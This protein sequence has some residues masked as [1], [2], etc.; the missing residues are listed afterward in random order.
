MKINFK[1]LYSESALWKIYE[2]FA[3]NG[4]L[5]YLGA[6]FDNDTK[7]QFDKFIFHEKH[8]DGRDTKVF[9]KY[10]QDLRQFISWCR[11]N[12]KYGDINIT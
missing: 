12:V 7:D 2:I 10:E 1:N 8:G 5:V 3:N 11:K 4:V 9:V 6:V